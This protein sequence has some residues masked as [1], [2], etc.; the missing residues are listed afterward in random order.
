PLP[1]GV[2]GELCIG[3]IGL[4]RG[5]LGRPELTAERFVPD[6]LGEDGARLYRTGDRARWSADGVIEYLGR[7]DQQVKLRGFRVEPQEI[8][9]RLLAQPNVLQAVVLVRETQAG[10][11]LIGW[12][13]ADADIS[14]EQ[15]KTALAAELPDYMVP[16]QLIRLAQ[17]PLSPSGK[18]DRGALP[19]P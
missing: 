16:A 14:P 5:Y 8:E 15:L 11:Q 9:A 6:P 3:G 7:F 2:P 4:A 17:M 1:A 12:Y 18:L 19:E 13:T 10:A